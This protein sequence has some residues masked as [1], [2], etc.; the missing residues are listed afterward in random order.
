MA[1]KKTTG[2]AAM[3]QVATEVASHFT[4]VVENIEQQNRAVMEAVLGMERR[5]TERMDLRFEKIELRLSALEFAVRKNSEDIRK[6]SEDIR[7]N[8][9]DIAALQ[10][11]VARLS[12]ILGADR[13]TNAIQ[14]L[15]ARV[16]ALE[17][18]IGSAA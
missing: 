15:E 1:T 7:K 11:E 5:L 14:A 10:R 6:N 13:E 12:T 2:A 18:R 8:S 3:K 16:A 17:A 9:E 4:A